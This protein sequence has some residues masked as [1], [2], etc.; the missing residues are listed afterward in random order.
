MTKGSLVRNT[1]SNETLRTIAKKERTPKGILERPTSK[2]V[3]VRISYPT[4]PRKGPP[5]PVLQAQKNTRNTTI[6]PPRIIHRDS[7]QSIN[8]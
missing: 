1:S 8:T 3:R 7:T 2:G 4:G 5:K 6:N